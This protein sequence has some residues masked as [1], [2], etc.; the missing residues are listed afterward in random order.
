MAGG[1]SQEGRDPGGNRIG[2]EWGFRRSPQ[3]HYSPIHPLI[4][5]SV[6]IKR[7]RPDR[8]TVLDMSLRL[9]GS[10]ATHLGPQTYMW[11]DVMSFAVEEGLSDADVL[12]ALVSSEAYAR[13]Y[14]SPLD[15]TS[16]VVEPAVHGRWWRSGVTANLFEL[17]SSEDAEAILQRWADDQDWTDPEYQQPADAQERL[18]RIYELLRQGILYRLAN[19]G[20]EQEHPSGWVVGGITGF[21]EF[22]AI[23]RVRGSAHLVVASDD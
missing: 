9:I 23:D 6:A 8:G 15:S 20:P 17:C 12:E 14:Q 2:R 13:S 3:L 4:W 22:V 7:G 11:V 1:D 19:P 5:L 21:H 16:E 18:R 10:H